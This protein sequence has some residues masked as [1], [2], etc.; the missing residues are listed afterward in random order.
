VRLPLMA[1]LGVIGLA[2]SAEATSLT[3]EDVTSTPIGDP[4]AVHLSWANCR[5]VCGGGII[6][7]GSL[8][9]VSIEL[10]VVLLPSRGTYITP[11]FG[12]QDLPVNEVIALSGWFN[13]HAVSQ[14]SLT[15]PNYFGTTLWPDS[16]GVNRYYFNLV[17]EDLG[18]FQLMQDGYNKLFTPTLYFLT[19]P[20]VTFVEMPV[21]EP[22]TLMLLTT[23]LLLAAR[24]RNRRQT[25]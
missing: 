19:S 17:A 9:P 3:I 12:P 11:P 25:E 20:E 14:G 18:P 13:G 24:R 10:D 8:N 16:G 2:A 21:P 7:L 15:Y 6:E 4:F 1:V 23:G 5:P 22:S